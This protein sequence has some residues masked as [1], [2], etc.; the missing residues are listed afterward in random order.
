MFPQNE[1]TPPVIKP[2]DF[3]HLNTESLF[4]GLAFVITNYFYGENRFVT[5]LNARQYT[6]EYYLGCMPCQNALFHAAFSDPDSSV[7]EIS[8]ITGSPF[9]QCQ[10]TPPIRGLFSL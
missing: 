2:K 6:E 3:P 8:H 4:L 7:S 10:Y 1:L 9:T 5:V